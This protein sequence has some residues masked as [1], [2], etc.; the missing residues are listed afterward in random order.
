MLSGSGIMRNNLE[1]LLARGKL[2][3]TQLCVPHEG[4]P[5]VLMRRPS[6][7]NLDSPFCEWQAG[8]FH[9]QCQPAR[10][11]Q[12]VVGNNELRTMWSAPA[13]P[14][15]HNKPAHVCKYRK[16]K[17]ISFVGIFFVTVRYIRQAVSARLK[18]QPEYSGVIRTILIHC[19]EFMCTFSHIWKVL[20]TGKILYFVGR[21]IEKIHRI[22]I[23]FFTTY[24]YFS[25][26]H[27]SF[28]NLFFLV[29]AF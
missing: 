22:L 18:G 6:I 3:V 16:F 27:N 5:P 17:R 24:S 4:N 29:F 7:F 13:L 26:F 9:P 15:S 11:R 19:I 25:F 21:S 12:K 10:L 23:Y 1:I 14:L 2:Q 8:E 28:F 20:V